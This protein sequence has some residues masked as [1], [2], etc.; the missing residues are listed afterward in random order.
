[1]ENPLAFISFN[2]FFLMF[3]KALIFKIRFFIKRITRK[4]SIG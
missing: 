2:E 3:L 1:L 4:L